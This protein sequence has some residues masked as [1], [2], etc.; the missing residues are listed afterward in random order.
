[1]LL[2]DVMKYSAKTR[3]SYH[4][5]TE[6]GLYYR[7]NY[8][9]INLHSSFTP[10]LLYFDKLIVDVEK[11][12]NIL[13]AE[14]ESLKQENNEKVNI[15]AKVLLQEVKDLRKDNTNLLE[16]IS[17]MSEELIASKTEM[18]EKIRLSENKLESKEKEL[19]ECLKSKLEVD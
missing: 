5:D 18:E 1:M 11:D 3:S 19:K 12:L 10:L 15:L 16:K 14:I 2:T 6:A 4:P 7:L 13:K 9:V 17:K 8:D